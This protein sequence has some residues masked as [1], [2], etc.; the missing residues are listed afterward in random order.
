MNYNNPNPR[1]N[2][3]N[4]IT[5]LGVNVILAPLAL[6]VLVIGLFGL[7]ALAFGKDSDWGLIPKVLVAIGVPTILYCLFFYPRIGNT[8]IIVWICILYGSLAIGFFGTIIWWCFK[9]YFALF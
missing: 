6:F 2:L 4:A 8:I 3:E 1:K 5:D 9:D 7:V